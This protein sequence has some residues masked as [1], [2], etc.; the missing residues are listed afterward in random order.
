M[1]EKTDLE[2]IKA[3]VDHHTS[4]EETEFM[5]EEIESLLACLTLA[6]ALARARKWLEERKAFGYRSLVWG[7]VVHDLQKE[8]EAKNG[9]AV[10]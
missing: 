9:S 7:E 3:I 6:H 8:V 10:K 1:T 2:K 4:I 5:R